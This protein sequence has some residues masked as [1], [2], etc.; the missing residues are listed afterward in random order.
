MTD[1]LRQAAQQALE[2]LEELNGLD[3]ETECVTIDVGDVIA[4]LRTALEQQAKPVTWDKP[5][6]SF[7]EWWDSNYEDPANPFEK[8]SGAYWAWAG[9]KAAQTVQEPVAWLYLEGFGALQNGKCWTA[10]PTKHEDCN[11]PLYIALPQ[12]PWVGLTEQERN[13]LEDA[14]GLV[15]GK[16]A[17]D[18]IEDALKER[19]K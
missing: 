13:D 2:A 1:Q 8:N 11:I 6:A 16:P 5:S 9:W 17:F 14:L 7:N 12:R 19:N 15:I 18:A 10:Y 3:T 4:A